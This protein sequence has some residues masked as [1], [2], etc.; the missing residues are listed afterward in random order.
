MFDYQS[1]KLHLSRWFCFF[2]GGICL[3]WAVLEKK[4][5]VSFMNL[6]PGFAF[7]LCGVIFRWSLKDR[8]RGL[9]TDASFVQNSEPRSSTD[10][11]PDAEADRP[12]E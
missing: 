5:A 6:Y 7:I 4:S 8:D 11:K 10:A 3:I 12:R 1:V 9:K 2:L